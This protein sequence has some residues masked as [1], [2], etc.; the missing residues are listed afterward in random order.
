MA[1]LMRL[2]RSVVKRG[3]SEVV[4]PRGCARFLDA[5]TGGDRVLRRALL[6]HLPVERVRLALHR[7]AYS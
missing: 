1:E 4:G 2:H 3:L 5:Y 6:A 7:L